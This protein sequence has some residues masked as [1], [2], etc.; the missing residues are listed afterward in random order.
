MTTTM[1]NHQEQAEEL[2]NTFGNIRLAIKVCELII[3]DYKS[4]RVKY[5][6]TLEASLD[7]AE[8]WIKVKELLEH[9]QKKF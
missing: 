8:D 6:L 3:D 2:I 4:Y 9:K 5:W 1:V 7:L